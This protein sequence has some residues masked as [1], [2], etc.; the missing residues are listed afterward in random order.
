[1]AHDSSSAGVPDAT[2]LERLDR[3]ELYL[4]ADPNNALLLSDAFELA[5]QCG[6]WD[7]AEFHLR[8]GQAL[9]TDT[10]S[11]GLKEGDFLLAQARYTEAREA[12]KALQKVDHPPASFAAVLLHNLAYI[13]FRQGQYAACVEQLSTYLDTF[14]RPD[15]ADTFKNN[16]GAPLPLEEQLLQQLWLRSLHRLVDLER[17]CAWTRKA[18]DQQSLDFRAAGIASL[19]AV[20]AADFVAARRWVD[21]ALQYAQRE[22]SSASLP[23]EVFVTQATLALAARQA[24][25]AIHWADQ[26]LQLNADD[27]RAW[28]AR[29]FALLLKGDLKAARRD[30]ARALHG[31]PEHIGTWHGQGW[32]QLLQQDV[33]AAQDSFASALALDRNFAESHGGLAVVLALKHQ[34]DNAQQHAE[35]ALGLDKNNLSG[36]YAQAI[37]NGDVT[38]AEAVQ[39]LA[40]RLLAGRVDLLKGEMLDIVASPSKSHL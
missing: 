23:I 31:I 19:I 34:N 11:W 35:R 15:R 22:Q 33:D 3:L 4:K 28:S 13:E 38:D 24:E 39:R 26:A 6:Q 17:A 1:M 14:S 16:A 37:L 5:L 25:M 32:T 20:D 7:R 21:F 36:R 8:H 18:E 12:L 40:Q 30:F 27:G 29:A 9:Q 10:L 2:A